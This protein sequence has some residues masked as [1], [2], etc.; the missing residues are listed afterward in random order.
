VDE[1]KIDLSFV[2]GIARDERDRALVQAIIEISRTLGLR[3]V[4]EGVERE[5]SWQWLVA[6]GCRAAQGNLVSGA[7][8]ATDFARWLAQSV[9]RAAKSA[10]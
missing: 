1:L 7:L 8:P 5:D 3:S 4:A 6:A 9:S 10:P 2:R